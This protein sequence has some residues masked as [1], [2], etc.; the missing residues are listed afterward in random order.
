MIGITGLFS[1]MVGAIISYV[2]ERCPSHIEAFE[3]AAAILVLGG[4]CAAVYG[5][6]DLF[7]A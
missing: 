2:S 1:V 3:T 4:F 5:L 7:I 6:S